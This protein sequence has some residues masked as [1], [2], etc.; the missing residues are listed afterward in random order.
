MRTKKLQHNMELESFT[1]TPAG[2][3]L[4]DEQLDGVSGGLIDEAIYPVILHV[5]AG[6]AID[7][8]EYT[9]SEYCLLSEAAAEAAA[10]L[11]EECSS[12]SIHLSVAVKIKI[13]NATT[14]EL[15]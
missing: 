12:D 2:Y 5:Q 10:Y 4:P 11:V 15:L 14:W 6:V 9:L 8:V 3:E 7:D 1:E 13:T